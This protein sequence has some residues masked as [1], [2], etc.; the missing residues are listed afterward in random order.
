MLPFLTGAPG[1]AVKSVTVNAAARA[2]APLNVP[3]KTG[4]QRSAWQRFLRGAVGRYGPLGRSGARTRRPLQA[5]R[6]L[7]DL[8]RAQLQVFVARPNPAEYGKLV[9]LSYTAIKG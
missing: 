6:D 8:E 4:A 3:V 2:S 9:K 7:A 1:W 5:D